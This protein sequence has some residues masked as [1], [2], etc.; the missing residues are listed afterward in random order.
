MRQATF[1]KCQPHCCSN[2]MK[3]NCLTQESPSSPIIRQIQTVA[4]GGS[5]Q[6][7]PL[8][9]KMLHLTATWDTTGHSSALKHF[10]TLV[11]RGPYHAVSISSL[12]GCSYFHHW[13]F[14]LTSEHWHA[15]GSLLWLFSPIYTFFLVLGGFIQ[16]HGFKCHLHTISTLECLTPAPLSPWTPDLHIQL[17]VWHLQLGL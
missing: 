2:K 9:N 14:P 3:W 16:T 1:D 12:T 7:K 10:I 5:S 4:S 15:L 8:L 11:I 6:P 17:P 13:L